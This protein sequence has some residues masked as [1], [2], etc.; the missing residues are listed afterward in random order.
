MLIIC[1]YPV[2]EKGG[3]D[4]NIFYLSVFYCLYFIKEINMDILEAQKIK[5][6]NPD[7]DIDKDARLCNS[8]E[9]I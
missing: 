1:G 7:L 4:G 9:I 8:R 2:V 3:I 5:D 6:R